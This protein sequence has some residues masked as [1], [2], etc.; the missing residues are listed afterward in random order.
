MAAVENRHVV[1]LRHFVD[2]CEQGEEVLF[3]VDVL[4]TMGR[5]QDVFAFLQT[6]ALVDITCLYL[7]QVVMEHFCHR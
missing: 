6:K 5:Q 1:L 7:S 4:F 2:G 3:G